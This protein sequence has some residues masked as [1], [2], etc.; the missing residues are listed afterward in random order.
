MYELTRQVTR[1]RSCADLWHDKPRDSL[2]ELMHRVTSPCDV[3]PVLEAPFALH[4]L[5]NAMSWDDIDIPAGLKSWV[6]LNLEV[7]SMPV[8]PSQN[9]SS[10]TMRETS[11]DSIRMGMC[12]WL[13]SAL[14]SIYMIQEARNSIWAK[15]SS[16][17]WLVVICYL[18]M[19]H[20][21]AHS[22]RRLIRL[23]TYHRFI[24]GRFN[25]DNTWWW[26]NSLRYITRHFVAFIYDHAVC[27]APSNHVDLLRNSSPLWLLPRSPSRPETNTFIDW[28]TSMW[29]PPQLCVDV[30]T[31]P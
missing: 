4:S 21:H 23:S 16:T 25:D 28:H 8:S 10:P 24:T 18:D 19:K 15:K 14:V 13:H 31:V 30:G 9:R 6:T 22:V 20:V 3:K 11:G 29:V 27:H 7:T 17:L 2:R 26:A 12:C 5:N 1:S